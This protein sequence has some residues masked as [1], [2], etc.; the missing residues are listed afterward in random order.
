K[1]LD[2]Q[3]WLRWA[4]LSY[5][6]P[7]LAEAGPEA[8]LNAV[9]RHLKQGETALTKLF[10]ETGNALFTSKPHTGV[11]WALEVLAWH[12]AYI[13]RVSLIL[14]HLNEMLPNGKSGNNP[15]RTLQE[16]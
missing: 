16:D 3:G 15:A 2:G 9:E 14:S 11:L 4:S 13:S 10:E 1:L 5:Q 8:F 12:R 6:L 7:L